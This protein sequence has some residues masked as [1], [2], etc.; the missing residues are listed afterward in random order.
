MLIV[1]FAWISGF[2]IP[3]LFGLSELIMMAKYGIIK[4]HL[5]TLCFT[6]MIR[7]LAIVIIFL[8]IKTSPVILYNVKQF[9]FLPLI[10]LI[11]VAI[12]ISIILIPRQGIKIITEINFYHNKTGAFWPLFISNRY[13]LHI[14][15][16]TTI[17]IMV[18]ILNRTINPIFS[19]IVAGSLWAVIDL[20]MRNFR[21]A[22]YNILLSVVISISYSQ[23]GNFS[24]P[25]L[26]GMIPQII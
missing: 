25:L 14:L 26:I 19:G 13:L 7:F 9:D 6:N 1:I 5:Y 15:Q 21:F 18:M 11:L 3:D 10:I 24:L 22:I 17:S 2:V 23:F 4:G 16:I 8:L 20:V 12:L